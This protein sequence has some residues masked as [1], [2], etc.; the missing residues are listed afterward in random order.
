MKLARGEVREDGAMGEEDEE[1]PPAV[2]W[3]DSPVV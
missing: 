2:G 1:N 3:L